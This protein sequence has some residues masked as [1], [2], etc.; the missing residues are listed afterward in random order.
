VSRAGRALVYG[1]GL[2]W[3]AAAVGGTAYIFLYESRPAPKAELAQM[4]PEQTGLA[5]NAN[6]F[7]LVM[8]VH[9]KCSCT[10]AS[11][12]ELNKLMLAWGGR[13]HA[14]A[15]VTK[16]FEVSDLWSE[17]DVT[18]RL[19]ELPNVT[20]VR[21]L[22]GA[23]SAAFGAENSGQTLLYDAAGQLVFEGGITAFRGHEGP[24]IGGETL[25]QIVAGEAAPS[26][27]TK[28]FGCS[29]Q[30]KFCPMHGTSHEGHDHGDHDQHV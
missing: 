17:T 25:K 28:V 9:P 26:R 8:A 23:K 7:S 24:S 22:G 2:L 4:W 20:V 12:A 21:D 13:V 14:I 27:H 3:V 30:D 16:P 10:R 6:G 19:R 18:A 5:R 15:L 11:V 1:A 29:L